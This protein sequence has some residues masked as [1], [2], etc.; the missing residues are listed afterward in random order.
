MDPDRSLEREILAEVR[1]GQ[2]DMMRD[3]AALQAALDAGG[4]R[5][6][7]FDRQMGELHAGLSAAQ[8][9]L[10]RQDTTLQRISVAVEQHFLDHRGMTWGRR[11]LAG[12]AGA[13][14]T[15]CVGMLLAVTAFRADVQRTTDAVAHADTTMADVALMTIAC[16]RAAPLADTVPDPLARTPYRLDCAGAVAAVRVRLD[17]LLYR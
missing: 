3:V 15:M 6:A 10:G 5:R 11:A 9:H 17:G 16:G 14:L 13:L 7:G 12:S 8:D 4:E 1:R 2:A